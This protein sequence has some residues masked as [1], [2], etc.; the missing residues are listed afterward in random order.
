[1]STVKRLFVEKRQPYDVEAQGLLSDLKGT[2]GI[3]ALEHVKIINRYDIE[4][5]SD[6]EYL[7]ARNTIF[8]EPPV[9]YAYDE[10][11]K[12]KNG[13]RAFAVEYLPGQYDQRA[14]SAAQCI[15]LLTQGERP[16]IKAARVIV[17]E[18]GITDSEFSAIKRYY[19]NPVESQEAK[20][21]KP[22]T[23][24]TEVEQPK[25]VTAI[26]GFTAM[27]EEQLAGLL[28]SMG[29]AMS[30][31][32]IAFCQGYFKNTE[33]RD[34]SVT[35]MRMIDTYWSDH[36]RHTTFLTCIDS[37]EF[38]EGKYSD[39]IKETFIDYKASREEIYRGRDDKDICLM[40]VALLAMKK[41]KKQGK[42]NDLDLSE[43]INACSIVVN[44]DIDGRNE[45]WL[46]MFKNETHNHP[47]EIEPFGGAATC[48]GGA[49]RDP[50]SGRVYVY[51]AMRVT[52]S[53]DPRAKLEDTIP[54]KL[55]QKKITT[56][57]AAGYSSYGNQI[58][59]ATGQVA[60]IYNEGY[61]AKR[62]EIGAVIGAAPRKNVVRMVP[63]A[64]DKIILLGGRTGRDGC[65]GATGS[66]KAHTEES[67]VSCGAEVQKGNPPTE[68]K[69]QRLFRNPDASTLIKRCNDFGAGGIS[70]AI[71][72]LA[73]GLEINLDVVPKKYEGL[74]GTEL[75]ISESQERMAVVVAAKDAGEFISHAAR[76]NL[77]AVVVAEVTEAARLKMTWRGNTIVDL[78]REFLN[79]NGAK[80]R[81]DIEV[82]APEE[83]TYFDKYNDI[84]VKSITDKWIENLQNLNRCS[85]KGLAERFD[86]TIGANTVLMPFGGKTQLTPAEGMAAKLPLMEGDT[87]TGTL[88]SYGYNSG[89]STWSPFH[90]AVFAVVESIAK[91]V[92]MGGDYGKARLTFQE[93]FEKP[94]KDARR[95]GKP[96]S[97]LLGG[98]YAQL[99]LGTAAIGGKDSM[100]G[101]FMDMDV[102]PTLV[103]F[104]VNTVN[105]NNVVSN[106]FKAAGSKVVMLKAGLDKNSL[107]DFEQLDRIYSRIYRLACEKA[108]LSASSVREGG[109]AEVISKMAFGNMLGFDFEKN[110]DTGMLF[111]PFYGSIILELPES[112]DFEKQLGDLE[113]ILLGTT[114]AKAEINVNGTVIALDMLAEK[115]QEPLER[116]FP[117]RTK[118]IMEGPEEYAFEARSKVSPGIKVARPRIFI[119]VFPGTNCEYDTK[120]VF[121]AAGGL[122]ETL[123]IRNMSHND[124]EESIKEMERIIDKSQIIMIPGGFSAGDEPEGSGKFIA[125]AFRNPVVS[126]AVMKLLKQRD[127]LVMGICN[128]FQ[129]LIKLGLLPFGEIRAIDDSCP[130]LTFNTI[131]RHQSCL[132]NTKITSNLSPWLN[133]VKVG[134]VHTIAVSHGEGRFTANGEVLRVLGSNG[135]IATQYVDLDGKATYD[136]AFNPNGS[137]NAIEGITSPDGRVFGKMGHSERIGSNLYRN[138]PGHKDQKLF[139]A[140]VEYFG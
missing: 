28:K 38:E 105:V 59:L 30:F 77:E 46:V 41:L 97:A 124:I 111:K 90:G 47:T 58:G 29:F 136:V 130:T 14:D 75:A 69:I 112:T 31:D 89:I 80:Q 48:L 137:V 37:V 92:A 61:V 34:P 8:S 86:S 115:W 109:I 52:G 16:E 36:C 17:F 27:N 138:V 96:L 13:S 118:K 88:M 114:A 11:Y 53:G 65:G 101:S 64:G 116:V 126:E 32:D 74:D 81:I 107:P 60:E 51:Q 35:E 63:Q 25:E 43:E 100:S 140:G 7:M 91:I 104:A 18:G 110:I 76:E 128:G 123:V 79:S 73:D 20:M 1:M 45:E 106:E 5:I 120:R 24:K 122:V 121:E 4:G 132:V 127:G 71:G 95:W 54:G 39:I 67:L 103:S 49:I 68:R 12:I 56:G 85:Q 93:Y 98:Y 62:M 99:K 15:Q 129:A 66:S 22:D 50:L 19:I 83:Q 134:D 57:A 133:K 21:D 117:T 26:E 23:L 10:E 108:I 102:P 55:P 78:S 42:L 139:Q 72:E 9:D 119:P 70:V 125:T 94:G 87:S 2:L 113:Y 3:K 44:A 131:G 40:D 6:E 135:Q 33:K 84:D 82:T